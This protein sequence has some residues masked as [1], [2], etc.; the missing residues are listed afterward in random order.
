MDGVPLRKPE[1]LLEES[2][3]LPTKTSPKDRSLVCHKSRLNRPTC[4]LISVHT[5]WGI[6]MYI[7]GRERFRRWKASC[8]WPMTEWATGVIAAAWDDDGITATWH[9]LR[10]ERSV[11][12]MFWDL[13]S[14][15]LHVHEMSDQM[16]P[17]LSTSQPEQVY[18]IPE[19]RI[20]A[21][22]KAGSGW[23]CT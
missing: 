2:L 15:V 3:W 7:M 9:F 13:F 20:P 4:W 23:G 1:E 17:A 8:L 21:D 19:H 18:H 22:L 6:L 14:R 10:D 11:F 16:H 5:S 12:S